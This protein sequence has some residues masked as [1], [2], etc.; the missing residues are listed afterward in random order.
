[1]NETR[2]V[3]WLAAAAVL[4]VTLA[5]CTGGQE[6][7]AS[8]ET[9]DQKAVA[10]PAV[11]GVTQIESISPVIPVYPGVE[12]RPDLSERDEVMLRNQYG[13]QTKVY[14]LA[15]QDSFPQVWHYYVQYLAQFRGYQP[16]SP[17]PPESKN[18]RT[19][20]VDLN[21]AMKDPFIPGEML[22]LPNRQI[23]LQL[24]ETEA[25]PPTVVRYIVTTPQQTAIATT[26]QGGSEPG[27]LAVTDDAPGG[28]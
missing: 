24:A 21:Q 22:N 20:Q 26:T 23:I 28:Q 19:M 17:Y 9:I 27:A 10:Q 1:M 16:P 6:T 7:A 13:P 4:T 18:W 11:N 8:T 15:S 14:T 3:R 12:Y 5:S 2:T 25:E